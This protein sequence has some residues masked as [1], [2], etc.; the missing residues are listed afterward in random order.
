M[1]AGCFF[2]SELPKEF[3]FRI[4]NDFVSF[5]NNFEMLRSFLYLR[6]YMSYLRVH[7]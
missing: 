2:Q 5:G 4:G 7:L 6:E 1:V 3:Y